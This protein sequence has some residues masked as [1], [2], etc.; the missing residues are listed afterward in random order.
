MLPVKEE[1]KHH[2]Y[3]LKR[4]QPGVDILFF[5][6]QHKRLFLQSAQRVAHTNGFSTKGYVVTTEWMDGLIDFSLIDKALQ[7]STV[8]LSSTQP[9]SFPV[10]I[11][12]C[13]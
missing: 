11:V 13:S 4:N 6:L 12:A 10:N 5:H 9:V 2:F 8:Q 7:S 3:F 1:N